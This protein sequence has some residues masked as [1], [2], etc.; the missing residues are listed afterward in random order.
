M[1]E[2]DSINF[3][4]WLFNKTQKITT[5]SNENQTLNISLSESNEQLDEA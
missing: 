1:R 2:R 3:C 4:H 5:K